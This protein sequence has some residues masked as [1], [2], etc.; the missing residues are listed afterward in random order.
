MLIQLKLRR[1]RIRVSRSY[2]GS[3]FHQTPF[4]FW[5]RTINSLN[6]FR[7]EI[8][9]NFKIHSIFFLKILS[10]DQNLIGRSILA[11]VWVDLSCKLTEVLALSSTG[12][13]SWFGFHNVY[14]L[15]DTAL[16]RVMCIDANYNTSIF[17]FRFHWWIVC[18][19]VNQ[20][21]AHYC[22]I[23]NTVWSNKKR[24]ATVSSQNTRS[25]LNTIIHVHDHI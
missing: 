21:E 10:P 11:Q 15:L 4:S 16:A 1:I 20:F 19:S 14:W 7:T 13:K 18:F 17:L 6:I 2:L 25:Y 24:D 22:Y 8:L 3:S 5:S 23:P 12:S 9:F